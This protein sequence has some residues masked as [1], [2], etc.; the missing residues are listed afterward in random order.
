MRLRASVEIHERG[1]LQKH[2]SGNR[3]ATNTIDCSSIGRNRLSS[4]IL[5]R[6]EV[7]SETHI[8]GGVEEA[9]RICPARNLRSR[10]EIVFAGRLQS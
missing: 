1:F 7:G 4:W 9:K 6:S 5:G 10:G 8:A 3:Q 2:K